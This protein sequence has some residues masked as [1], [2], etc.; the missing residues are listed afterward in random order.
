MRSILDAM[1]TQQ[2]WREDDAAHDR[3]MELLYVVEPLKRHLGD[4]NLYRPGRANPALWHPGMLDLARRMQAFLRTDTRWQPAG[5][6]APP[7]PSGWI[8]PRL[9]K[10]IG[11]LV[12]LAAEVAEPTQ[13][14]TVGRQCCVVLE[15]EIRKRTG[16]TATTHP[17]RKE[18]V[19]A[20]FKPRGPLVLGSND[21]ETT[22][23]LEF[24]RGLLTGVGNP[25]AHNVVER[26]EPYA[27]GVAGSVSLILTELDER[28]GPPA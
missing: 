10:V 21:A 18:L 27:M 22:G 9:W 24:T 3:L 2:S 6:A 11:P 26:A 13:W 15:S 12:K 16:L 14:D 17:G 4:R 23:W 1:D 5:D 25:V 7:E 8:H 19:T 20:A 28:F